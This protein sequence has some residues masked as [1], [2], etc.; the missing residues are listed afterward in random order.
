[1]RVFTQ[2]DQCSRQKQSE[3]TFPESEETTKGHM[4][5]VKSGVRSTKAQGEEPEEIQLAEAELAELRRKHRDIYVTVKEHSEM[6]HTDQTGRFPVVS[7][8]GH[9]YIMTLVDIDSNYIAMEPMRSR[10]TTEL[11]KVYEMIMARLKGAGI[12]PC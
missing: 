1:M 2:H 7:D 3:S 5:R 9:K 11:I 12:Q 10:E 6:I 8:A 4:R